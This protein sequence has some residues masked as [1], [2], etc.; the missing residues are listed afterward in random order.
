MKGFIASFGEVYY[1]LYKINYYYLILQLFQILFV[2]GI[3]AYIVLKDG[4][5]TPDDLI[6]SELKGLVKS[7]IAA[8]AQPDVIQ[9]YHVFMS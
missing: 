9:V 6:V 3:Y 8:Y 1:I 4:V 5:T 7:R 2:V